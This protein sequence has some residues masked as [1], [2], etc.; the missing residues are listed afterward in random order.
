ML[1]SRL[2]RVNEKLATT[3]YIEIVTNERVKENFKEYI[4][5]DIHFYGKDESRNDNLE[6]DG[7][8]GF[9][10]MP[11]KTESLYR[12]V[13]Y[14]MEIHAFYTKKEEDIFAELFPDLAKRNK[15]DY[16][17]RLRLK[18]VHN[19]LIKLPPKITLVY[20]ATYNNIGTKDKVSFSGPI[21]TH[22]IF[23]NIAPGEKLPI[24]PET[25]S[26][27]EEFTYNGMKMIILSDLLDIG[28]ITTAL[29]APGYII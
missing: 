5:E 9:Y 2:K 25:A 20:L 24:N 10:F 28:V 13:V 7:Y 3:K 12:K 1:F 26:D 17:R 11:A 15:Q 27:F 18:E 29:N 8:A 21:I 19:R 4:K 22:E 23:D 16:E 14:A 6:I